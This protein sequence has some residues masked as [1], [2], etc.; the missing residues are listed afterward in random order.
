QQETFL[1]I[2]SEKELMLAVRKCM[3][4]LFTNRAISYRFDKGFSMFDV[5]L[6]VGVQK[7]VR[8]DLGASGVMFSID[9]ENG[10]DKVVIINASYGLGEM[11]V[12]GKVTPD[13]YTVFKPSLERGYQLN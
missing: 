5:L 3:S 12:L 10:F 7:M 8:S 2:N 9:T 13:E 11:V 4:S 1:N 6:S